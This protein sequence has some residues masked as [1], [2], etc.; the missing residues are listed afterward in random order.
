L[1]G[2][3]LPW[4]SIHAENQ[5]VVTIWSHLTRGGARGFRMLAT[6][7]VTKLESVEHGIYLHNP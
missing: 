7:C 4:V 6:P 1:S 5:A 2:I 3:F